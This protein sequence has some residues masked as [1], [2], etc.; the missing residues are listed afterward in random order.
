VTGVWD[1]RAE[2]YRTSPTH[3][4]GPDLDLLV[5]WAGPG[6]GR[7]ALDVA[8]GGGH[9]A[10]RLEEA[11]FTV[12][13]V[14]PAPGMRPTV[15]ARAEDLPFAEGSFA[16]VATRIA[17]HHFDDV[18]AAVA[19]LAR[20]GKDLVLVEDMV[21]VDSDVEEAE[22][23]RDPSHVQTYTE[24]QWRGFLEGAG[25]VIE[26]V[27][28]MERSTSLSAWLSRTGCVD[29]EAERVAKLLAHRTEGDQL[30][31]SDVLLRARKPA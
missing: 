26:E 7:Q 31:L 13:S 15:I 6:E 1:E 16:L 10:R 23:L 4:A 12:T 22:K 25:L 3:A 24:G 11:G 29:G 30:A 20:V 14:D 28:L 18:R 21:Y 8:T 17:A 19:E 27:V 2:A 5:E 9:L